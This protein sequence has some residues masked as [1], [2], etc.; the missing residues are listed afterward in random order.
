MRNEYIILENLEMLKKQ[1]YLKGLGI[2]RR[3]MLK[4]IW[5]KYGVTLSADTCGLTYELW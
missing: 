4:W 2:F 5:E 1:D 3:I